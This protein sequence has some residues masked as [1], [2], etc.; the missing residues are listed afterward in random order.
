MTAT[1]ARVENEKNRPKPLQQ[2]KAEYRY[3]QEAP[4]LTQTTAKLLVAQPPPPPPMTT[5]FA[6]LQPN[7]SNAGV[8]TDNMNKSSIGTVIDREL[9]RTHTKAVNTDLRWDHLE[10]KKKNGKTNHF[11]EGFRSY[12][13]EVIKK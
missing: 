8:N 13:D 12:Y 11:N 4:K 6:T 7:K 9:I 2:P 1:T 5:I 3:V 10:L